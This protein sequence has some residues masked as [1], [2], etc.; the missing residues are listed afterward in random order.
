MNWYLEVLKKYAVFS[1]RAR[2]KELWYFTLINSI[3][4]LVL[5]ITDGLIGTFS[6]ETGVGLL[7]SIYNL[8][9]II[10]NLAVTVRRLHDTD[11]SAWWLLIMLIPLIGIIV[12]LVF[13]MLDSNAGENKFGVNPKDETEIA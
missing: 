12:L 4:L 6:I 8:A 13:M 9:I 1:G 10:P 11:R 3:I 5:T 2:R 7:S